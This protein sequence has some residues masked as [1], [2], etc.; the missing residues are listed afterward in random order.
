MN[1]PSLM[2]YSIVRR[3][4]TPVAF[5]IIA[6]FTNAA[7]SSVQTADKQSVRA[8]IAA[9]SDAFAK[10][11]AHAFSMVFHEDDKGARQLGHRSDAQ[12]GL[13]RHEVSI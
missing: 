4:V 5:L 8:L 2:T 11:N 13:T 6:S 9:M 12:H 1:A 3:F 10:L 7:D